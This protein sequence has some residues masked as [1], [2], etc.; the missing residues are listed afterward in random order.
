MPYEE[1]KEKMQLMHGCNVAFAVHYVSTAC[2]I[3]TALLFAR[4]G[5]TQGD[6]FHAARRPLTWVISIFLVFVASNELLLHGLFFGTRQ[7]TQAGDAYWMEAFLHYDEI[8]R[9][10]LKIGLPILW[11]L[12]AFALLARGVK[13]L[14]GT[15]G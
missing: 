3:Y 13:N 1:L 10:I 14:P 7:M 11:G 12:L 4:A 2:L 6:A 15:S 9:R 8:T 5:D